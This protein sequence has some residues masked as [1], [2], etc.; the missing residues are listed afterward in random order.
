MAAVRLSP[1]LRLGWRIHRWL[2]R[3]SGGRIGSRMN[4]F[5]VLL[6]TTVGR[7]SGIERR[8][9]LQSLRHGD[10]WAVVA[11]HA[12][13]D[14]EPAWLLN[15]RGRPDATVMIGGETTAVRARETEGDERTE[16]W[17]R[18]VAIDDAYAEYERRTS[19]HIAVV[20]LEPR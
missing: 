9:A 16:L 18:F 15:L 1:M 19:R 20:V 13:D 10:G 17:N 11:S 12:G 6:L 2:F 4:G 3:I 5:E 8:V 7:R 14:R